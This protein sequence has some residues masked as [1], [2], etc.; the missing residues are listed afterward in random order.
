MIGY[1]ALFRHNKQ[2]FSL[3]KC[4]KYFEELDASLWELTPIR[5]TIGKIVKP[6]IGNGPL[7]VCTTR[8]RAECVI[9][10]NTYSDD[11]LKCVVYECEYSP[12]ST[13]QLS[14][15]CLPIDPQFRMCNSM[16]DVTAS[17]IKL[18]RRVS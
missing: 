14:I 3:S 18:I 17:E 9:F 7:A 4:Y 5:Y 12:S 8:Q 10:N 11:K 15:A 1:K 2:L 6:K 13:N 16:G